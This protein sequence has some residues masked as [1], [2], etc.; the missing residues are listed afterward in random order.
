VARCEV[1]A[2]EEKLKMLIENWPDRTMDELSELL[3][4]SDVH[5]PQR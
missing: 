2:T 3:D 5:H 4:V 1:E